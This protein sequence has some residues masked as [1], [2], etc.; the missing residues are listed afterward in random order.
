MTLP[1]LNINVTVNLN[2]PPGFEPCDLSALPT[3]E[4]IAVVAEDFEKDLARD[5]SRPRHYY[6]TRSIG[7][8]IVS[9]KL[10]PA[11]WQE[12]ARAY[13]GR[14]RVRFIDNVRGPYWHPRYAIDGSELW[15]FDAV[16]GALNA[17][18]ADHKRHVPKIFGDYAVG[19][20]I[21]IPETTSR[22]DFSIKREDYLAW[23]AARFAA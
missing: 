9:T 19:S 13:T 2:Y 21:I 22:Y 7:C 12:L 11:L 8:T 17:D 23:K 18:C 1:A 14:A 5:P 15:Y 16:Y 10:T 6:Q 3:A 20:T 4:A